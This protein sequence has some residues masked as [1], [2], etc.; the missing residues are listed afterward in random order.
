MS[1]IKLLFHHDL[2][3][4]T[5]DF[6]AGNDLL[7][8]FAKPQRTYSKLWLSVSDIQ[9]QT[10]ALSSFESAN[11]ILEHVAIPLQTTE[12]VL[13]A[14][15]TEPVLVKLDGSKEPEIERFSTTLPDSDCLKNQPEQAL[16][17]KRE[18]GKG[19]FDLCILSL[20]NRHAPV[21]NALVTLLSSGFNMLSINGKR[22]HRKE[23]L[24]EVDK[25]GAKLP[26]G[27]EVV[28]PHFRM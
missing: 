16:V 7:A 24:Y 22:V 2:P 26:H 1:L 8:L 9:K 4:E 15:L 11:I 12:E 6:N 25:P 19:G 3:L 28:Q 5:T 18:P 23:M 10:F 27:F 17:L 14:V 21:F 20:S 13:S